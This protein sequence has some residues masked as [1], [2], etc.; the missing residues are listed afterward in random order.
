[1][2]PIWLE[3]YPPGV[4]SEASILRF[5]SLKDLLEQSC[6][7]FR[8]RPAF[9]NLGVSLSYDEL[10]RRSQAFGA[11]LQHEAGLRRGERVAIMLPNLL[12]YPV[13][14]FGALRAGM[15]VVNVNPL[16]TAREL[17]HQLADSGAT[18]IV[19]L[20]NFAHTLQEIVATTAVRHVITT[21]VGDLLPPFKACL[22]NFAVK[23]IKR[24]VPPW[25]LPGAVAFNAALGRGVHHRL[26]EVQITQDDIAFLQY[27]GGTTGVAK[28]AILT[29]GNLVANVEQTSAWIGNILREGEEVVI[30][31]LPLYHVFALTANL[32]TFVKWG[33]NDVLITNPRDIPGFIK[34]LRKTRFTVITGVN[35]LYHK[36]LD[37]PGFERVKQAN[38]GALK[39]AVAGGMSV[40]RS[41]AERWQQRMGVPLIEGYGLT[42]ASPI[43]CANP[44][45]AREFSG[46]I[47]MPIPSTR[48]EIRD[49][50]GN[51]L[52]LGEAGELCV[53][54][55]QVMR[56]YWNMPDETA[57]VL[58]VDG[59]LRTGDICEM[60]ARGM[61]RFVDRG[62]DVVVVSG[63]KVYPNEV[64]EVLMLHPGVREAGVTG[65]PDEKSGEVVKAFVV[66]RNP[67]LTA[68]E[69]IA[70]CRAN[71]AA[72]KVPKQVEFRD[73]LPKSPIGK[74]LRRALKQVPAA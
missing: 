13:A 64:E 58:S 35:T 18:A 41:V 50:A 4:P 30:T 74:V 11:W 43:V 34:V 68:A 57:S 14:L 38:A 39:L 16:Y 5:D 51:P 44:L 6:E 65:V 42:E 72:Y 32:L 7:R 29:H 24:G 31:P 22:V 23:W 40:Q 37:A 59:W 63:F 2:N 54:G 27:T 1:M 8:A 9:T 3:H 33:A 70:H 20:E 26:D 10:D 17:Q 66:K 48:V 15:V 55:P 62:K 73:R 71:L 56:G 25:Q 52:P 53:Q 19:V 28:G 61:V 69:L 12:Q 36:L 21:R 46:A 45:D 47:G 67:A 49:E 60:D